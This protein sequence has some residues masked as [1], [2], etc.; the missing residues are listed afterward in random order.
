M[1]FWAT[2]LKITVISNKRNQIKCQT[3]TLKFKSQN[4]Q[5]VL[6]LKLFFHVTFRAKK[7]HAPL[8]KN[9]QTPDNSS[10]EENENI[11]QSNS[12]FLC[13]LSKTKRS[14]NYLQWIVIYKKKNFFLMYWKLLVNLF[15]DCIIINRMRFN[16]FQQQ[17]MLISVLIFTFKSPSR[18]KFIKNF[19]L[20]DFR[21]KLNLK[22]W[23]LLAAINVSAYVLI[24][25]WLYAFFRFRT[26]TSK[27]KF[28]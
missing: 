8:S 21:H 5:P 22:I 16:S 7:K 18:S 27:K 24:E 6:D 1:F 10:H 19:E 20:F 2:S 13:Y 28:H 3:F 4:S 25:I 12:K 9:E 14:E 23:Y 26:T 15:Q 11:C 17:K